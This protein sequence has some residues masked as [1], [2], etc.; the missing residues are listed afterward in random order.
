MDNGPPQRRIPIEPE[1][2]TVAEVLK[3]A[4]FSPPQD[5]PELEPFLWG[6]LAGGILT[7]AAGGVLLY[8]AWPYLVRA[9]APEVVKAL[10]ALRGG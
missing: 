1:D 8:F 3:E 5:P 4:G 10:E 2:I 7:I 9:F 6:M